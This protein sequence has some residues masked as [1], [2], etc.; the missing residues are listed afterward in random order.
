M[1]ICFGVG[2]YRASGWFITL[3][4]KTYRRKQATI[5]Y[6]NRLQC[7][8]CIS[9]IIKHDEISNGNWKAGLWKFCSFNV[10]LLSS[11]YY[12]RGNGL[13]HL[14]ALVRFLLWGK[15]VYGFQTATLSLQC[16]SKPASCIIP[17]KRLYNTVR[18]CH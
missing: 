18:N 1:T 2:G 10:A 6:V 7:M 17:S 5:K 9:V 4:P 11:P 13:L 14:T 12:G 8:K 16:S 3:L 15:N